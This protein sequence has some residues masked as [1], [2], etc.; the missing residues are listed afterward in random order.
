ME[1][2]QVR[3]EIT[4]RFDN[5]GDLERMEPGS[6]NNEGWNRPVDDSS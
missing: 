6:V 3:I 5:T 4:I 2:L 1:V